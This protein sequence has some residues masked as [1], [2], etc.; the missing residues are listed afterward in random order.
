MR[1]DIRMAINV[2]LDFRQKSDVLLSRSHCER[3]TFIKKQSRVNPRDERR[4]YRTFFIA[5]REVEDG[6]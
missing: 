1:I 4:Q 5:G 6:E 3:E 2:S